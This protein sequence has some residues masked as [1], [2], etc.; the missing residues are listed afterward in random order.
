[1]R[2]AAHANTSTIGSIAR[3]LQGQCAERKPHRKKA[4]RPRGLQ[5]VQLVG[6]SKDIHIRRQVA[7]LMKCMPSRLSPH[8]ARQVVWVH[9]IEI[10]DDERRLSPGEMRGVSHEKRRLLLP[11]LT[12]GIQTCPRTGRPSTALAAAGIG[13]R[14]QD[15]NRHSVP[16]QLKV[17]KRSTFNF[18][19]RGSGKPD[20]VRDVPA[21]FVLLRDKLPFGA[22]HDRGIIEL[23]QLS[24][25]LG[26]MVLEVVPIIVLTKTIPEQI[27]RERDTWIAC[28]RPAPLRTCRDNYDQRVWERPKLSNL[29]GCILDFAAAWNAAL[30][31]T[32][33]ETDRYQRQ[34][35]AACDSGKLRVR[36]YRRSLTERCAIAREFGGIQPGDLRAPN[37]A[38]S[39]ARGRAGCNYSSNACSEYAPLFPCVLAV[40]VT[41]HRSIIAGLGK[42][43]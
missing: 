41:A 8:V 18:S 40:V 15:V 4:I 23:L 26:A 28:A 24:E 39:R 13:L 7:Q 31:C 19:P 33:M 3:G 34:V 11:D 14:S 27:A 10:P 20:A 6:R 5:D 36:F 37:R 43:T 38:D 30:G 12:R 22:R 42:R 16:C 2:Q 35:H 9:I 25:M 1:M 32:M 29:I 21:L 17:A